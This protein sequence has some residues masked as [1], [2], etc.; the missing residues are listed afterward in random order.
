MELDVLV[1]ALWVVWTYRWR[2]SGH[3][4]SMVGLRENALGKRMG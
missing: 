1:E 2:A 3:G 4:W